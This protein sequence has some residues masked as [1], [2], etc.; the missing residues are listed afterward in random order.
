MLY[1]HRSVVLHALLL[2]GVDGFAISER[3]VVMPIV[4]MFHVNAW[5]LPYAAMLPAPTWSCPGPRMAPDGW[6]TCWPGTG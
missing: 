3:D 1:S 6:S 5:G 4:P 2:L